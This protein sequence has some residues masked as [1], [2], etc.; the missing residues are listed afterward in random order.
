MRRRINLYRRQAPTREPYDTVLIVCEG[1]KSEPL[2]L[3]GLMKAHNLSSANIHFV[4]PGS[5]PVTM[6]TYARARLADYVRVYCVF[7]GDNAARAQAALQ[8][9][10]SC[11]EGQVLQDNSQRWQGIVSTPCFELWLLLHFKYS[12]APIAAD[13]SGTP[14]DVTVKALRSHLKNYKKAH[15]DIYGLVEAKTNQAIAH[16]KRLARHNHSTGSTN[17]ATDMHLLVEYLKRIRSQ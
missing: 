16:A 3:Q 11:P 14:G 10:R 12:D 4:S 13:A 17:P 6:A 8:M 1:E 7:D 2:Y 15:P 5:D 9:I